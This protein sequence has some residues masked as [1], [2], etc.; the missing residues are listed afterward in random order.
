VLIE[1]LPV[2]VKTSRYVR[3]TIDFLFPVIDGLKDTNVQQK[4]NSV[5]FNSMLQLFALLKQPDL[6]THVSGTYEIKT[7]ERDVLSIALVGLGD[8]HGAHPITVIKSLSIDI[9]SGKVYELKDLFKPQSDYIKKISEIIS[10]QIK[11][12][13]IPIFGEFKEISPNQD[14]YIS[15]MSI[16]VY[17]QQSDIT[18]YAVGFPNFPIPTYKLQDSIVEDGLLERMSWI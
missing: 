7:N 6:I 15:G 1:K 14:Y 2:S 3:P 11:E 8:F 9:K 16:I 13:D 5:I 12:R 10:E 4:I 18:P 17:Y